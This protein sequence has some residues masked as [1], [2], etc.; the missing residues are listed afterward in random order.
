MNLVQK[1]WHRILF[2]ISVGSAER[3]FHGQPL[4]APIRA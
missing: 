1:D 3:E 2:R 4:M